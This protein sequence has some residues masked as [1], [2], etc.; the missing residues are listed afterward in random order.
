[1]LKKALK[2]GLGLGFLMAVL[3]GCSSNSATDGTQGAGTNGAEMSGSNTDATVG[4]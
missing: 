2:H 4:L 1:M 3:V